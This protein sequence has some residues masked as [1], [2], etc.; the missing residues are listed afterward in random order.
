M[1]APFNVY[2]LA[3]KCNTIEGYS[4]IK[5]LMNPNER[6]YSDCFSSSIN[7]LISEYSDWP[8]GQ[9]FG[10]SDGTYATKSFIDSM[11]EYSGLWDTL[12]TDFTPYLSVIKKA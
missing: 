9:G 5:K 7:D 10:S 8:D 11:I 12:K 3:Y 4:L 1:N 2:R 6:I